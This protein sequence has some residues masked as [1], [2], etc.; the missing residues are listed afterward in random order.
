MILLKKATRSMF[1]NK[2]AYLSCIALMILG[3]FMYMC[4]VT[5]LSILEINAKD[6]Y[7][8]NNLGDAFVKIVKAPKSALEELK[9]IDGIET[10]NGR[11]VQEV[12]I[13]DDDLDNIKVL[14]LISTPLKK[15]TKILNNYIYTSNDISEYK[16]ILLAEDFLTVHNYKENTNI[17]FITNQKKESFT[18]K[19]GVYSPEY[20]YL[21]KDSTSL[22]N[23]NAN[24]NFAYASEEYMGNIFDMVNCYNDI[25]FSLKDGYTYDDVK[26]EVKNVLKKY[27]FIYMH[28]R[29]DLTSY[30]FVNEEIKN[31]VSMGK[32]M[33]IIFISISSFIL[34]LTLKRIIEQDRGQIGTLKAFGYSKRQII[35]H[36][37]FNGA[38]TSLIAGVLGIVLSLV[39]VIPLLEFYLIYFKM[40]LTSSKIINKYFIQGFLFII[41]G[42]I[43]GAYLGVNKIIKLSPSEAMRSEAPKVVKNN[44]AEKLIFL[45]YIVTEE[46]FMGIRNMFRNRVRS[47]FV[48]LG[49]AFSFSIL[50]IVGVMKDLMSNQFLSIYDNV[51]KYDG[52]IALENYVNYNDGVGDLL[53]YNDV[54]EAEG[55]LLEDVVLYNGYINE[56]VNLIGIKEKSKLYRSYDEK[57]EKLIKI[58]EAGI[59]L[60]KYV[61]NKISAEVGDEI[62]LESPYLKD[63]VPIVVSS[64]INQSGIGSYVN[65]N[66]LNDIFNLNN[67]INCLVFTTSDM[68]KIRKEILNGKNINDI[69]SKDSEKKSI[70]TLMVNS[71]FMIDIIIVIGVLISFIIIYNSSIISL[72]ERSREYATLRV[73]GFSVKRVKKIMNFEYWLLCFFGILCGIPLSNVMLTAMAAHMKFGTFQFP[74]TYSSNSYVIAVV[75]CIFS[76]LFSNHM[77]GKAVKKLKLVEVLKEKE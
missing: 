62:L 72:S 61:A 59:V 16:D 44:I 70:E 36:Y 64:I 49:I 63:K 34:Y 39:S 6:Y 55:V 71:A 65:F 14:K 50:C 54:I 7:K 41:L 9:S 35:I 13:Y 68:Q 69:Y 37:I 15:E 4:M 33:G 76:V 12:R 74:D 2:K 17:D 29:E 43:S 66:Y 11:I 52:K 46:S 28:P 38:I 25:S 21:V 20:I 3:A 18:I 24:Y 60:N 45:K 51:Y 19:G 47:S 10:V 56:S 40:P 53:Q 1:R 73:L 31:G 26:D 75:G 67:K 8:N 27:G 32:S 48:I 42:G 23:N 58:P 57:K 5:T 30:T 22:F 77:S